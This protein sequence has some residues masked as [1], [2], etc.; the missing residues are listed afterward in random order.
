MAIFLS[1]SF[2]R[3][4]GEVI[5]TGISSWRVFEF[6][7]FFVFYDFAGTSLGASYDLVSFEF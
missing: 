2:L 4:P 1:F 3:F 5:S 7:E 6:F